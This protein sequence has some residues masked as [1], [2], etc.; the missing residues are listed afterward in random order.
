[1]GLRSETKFENRPGFEEVLDE[2]GITNSLRVSQ[3]IVRFQYAYQQSNADSDLPNGFEFKVIEN[4]RGSYRLCQIYV[5]PNNNYRALVMFPHSRIKGQLLAYW[6]Y[7]FKKQR[8]NDHPKIE[9][10]KV[11]AREYWNSIE[12]A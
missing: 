11:I 12:R 10:A 6:V 3:H 5:G 8:K 4:V 9:R 1:M 2:F 7:A